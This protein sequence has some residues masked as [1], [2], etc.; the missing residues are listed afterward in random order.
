MRASSVARL[1]YILASTSW[2]DAVLKLLR[3]IER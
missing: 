3:Q 1:G 2:R